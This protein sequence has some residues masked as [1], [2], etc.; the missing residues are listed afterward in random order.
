MDRAIY[1]RTLLAVIGVWL[2][3]GCSERLLEDFEQGRAVVY[4]HLDHAG[5]CEAWTRSGTRVEI[6][7]AVK[8]SYSECFLTASFY[9]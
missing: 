7:R 3:P 2:Y 1:G 6:G 8:C 4:L 9:V 5:C